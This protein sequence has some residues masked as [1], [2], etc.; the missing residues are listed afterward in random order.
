MKR[1]LPTTFAALA[2]SAAASAQTATFA[3]LNPMP[4][5]TISA[6]GSAVTTPDMARLDVAVQTDGGNAGKA[7]TANAKRMSAVIDALHGAGIAAKDLRTSAISLNPTYVYAAGQPPRVTGF[8][9]A[10]RLEVVVHDLAK[11]GPILDALAEAGVT[12]VGQVQMENANP[13]AAEDAARVDA[14]KALEDKAQ[15]LAHAAGYRIKGLVSLSDA[16]P[17]RPTPQPMPNLMM[18]KVAAA[19]ETP[20]EAGESTVSVRVYGVFALERD[21]TESR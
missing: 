2:L 8:H 5:L 1:L 4:T 14:V 16:A 15:L 10:N 17:V 20:V 3:P 13:R 7:M 19:P 11:L 18:A 9:A 21:S 6:E 12:D